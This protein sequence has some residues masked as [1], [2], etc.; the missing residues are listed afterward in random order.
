[1][2]NVDANLDP[3][4]YFDEVA[5][6]ASK[7]IVDN[8]EAEQSNVQLTKQKKITMYPISQSVNFNNAMKNV[9]MIIMMAGNVGVEKVQGGCLTKGRISVIMDMTIKVIVFNNY[10]FSKRCLQSVLNGIRERENRQNVSEQVVSDHIARHENIVTE[11]GKVKLTFKT[12]EKEK[13]F[14]A[15]LSTAFDN[16]VIAG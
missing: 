8:I 14:G 4:E 3:Q 15:R 5:A 6:A 16:N 2:D 13:S 11:E 1:M 7:A 9:G 10:V 12:E